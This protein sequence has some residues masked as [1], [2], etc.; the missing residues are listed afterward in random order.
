M[1]SWTGTQPPT[2]D[3]A[4]GLVSGAG[5]YLIEDVAVTGSTVHDASIEAC[6]AGA[7]VGIR[8]P[9]PEAVEGTRVRIGER[10]T[11]PPA[12]RTEKKEVEE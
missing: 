4:L 5:N 1:Q 12:P 7:L 10:L 6:V 3:V 8:L 11:V 9:V 2:L